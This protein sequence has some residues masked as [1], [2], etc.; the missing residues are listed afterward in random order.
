MSPTVSV[1]VGVDVA[2]D[3]VDVHVLPSGTS[4]TVSTA[5]GDLSRLA[6]RLKRLHP[7]RVVLEATGGLERPVIAA[8]LHAG[9]PVVVANPKQVRSYA[10]AV[11]IL[12]KTDA[13]DA[14]VIA[15][16]AEATRPDPRP[17][18]DPAHQA[19]GN[20]LTRREQLLKM[21]HAE[22]NRHHRADSDPVRNSCIRH[23]EWMKAEISDIDA[24]L[25][26]LIAD[27]PAWRVKDDL[28]RSVPG[29]GRKIAA[30]LIAN[31]PELGHLNRRQIASLVGVAPFNKDSGRRRGKR[32]IRA[33]RGDVRRALYMGALVATRCNPVI[34]AYYLRLVDKGK[35]PKVALTAAMRKLLTILNVMVK[36]NTPWKEPMIP[37][38]A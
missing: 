34:Q 13:L 26:R 33:G 29:I 7:T 37:L 20:L 17:L 8:L 27:S 22:S 3:K 9:L 12:A 32:S 4:F 28:L 24:R 31:L 1:N 11:G 10:S 35:P 23:I 21:I 15:R 2:Q 30:K 14:L 18:P 6:A 38:A 16:F 5:P 25:V 36:T 19:L